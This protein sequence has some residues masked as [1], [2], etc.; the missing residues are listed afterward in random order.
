MEH[1]HQYFILSPNDSMTSIGWK[2]KIAQMAFKP[3][4]FLLNIVWKLE[5][6]G[7]E[8]DRNGCFKPR[9]IKCIPEAMV[10]VK[11]ISNTFY[12]FILPGITK[13]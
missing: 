13:A 8:L 12:R 7:Y 3:K 10:L 4:E 2:N 6:K 5:D 11:E 9:D 1:K